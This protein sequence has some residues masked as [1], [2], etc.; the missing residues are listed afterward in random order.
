MVDNCEGIL[1]ALEC[2]IAGEA[3]NIGG[4]NECSNRG[5]RTLQV[6]GLVY[7]S[8]RNTKVCVPIM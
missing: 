8:Y 5:V 1:A 3:Y 6:K 7:G 4:S 2:G